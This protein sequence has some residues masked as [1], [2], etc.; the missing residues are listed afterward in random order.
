LKHWFDWWQ[1][2]QGCDFRHLF[3]WS[4]NSFALFSSYWYIFLFF[5]WLLSHILFSS[6]SGQVD[7]GLRCSQPK[8]SPP[9]ETDHMKVAEDIYMD[10][11][12]M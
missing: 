12:K 6:L 11:I 2:K 5:S 3:F 10:M 7:I 8:E 4:L 9:P 1:E